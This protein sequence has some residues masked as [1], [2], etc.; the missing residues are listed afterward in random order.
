MAEYSDR[1][2]SEFNYAVSFLNRLNALF[3]VCDEASMALDADKW[4]HAL[5]TISREIS[6][7]ID[8]T[9][10]LAIKDY[11]TKISPEIFKSNEENTYLGMNKI[12]GELYELLND[13]E[14][15]LRKYIKEAGYKTK[16]SEDPRFALGR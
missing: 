6:D 15:C 10:K 11:I 14:V 5:A 4:F 12:S 1:Q 7:D 16:Y 2:Q 13:F 9:R 8:D 3:Y